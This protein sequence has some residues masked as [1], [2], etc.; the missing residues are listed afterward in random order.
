MRIAANATQV[1]SAAGV[2]I[3]EDISAILDYVEGLIGPDFFL[4]ASSFFCKYLGN[5]T[6][7]P[8]HQDAQF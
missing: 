5:R 1:P 3:A 8:W 4:M 7:L 6:E 2:D